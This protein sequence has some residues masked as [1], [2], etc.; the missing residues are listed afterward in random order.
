MTL[1]RA[2]SLALSLVVVWCGSKIMADQ[3]EAEAVAFEAFEAS[4]SS[5]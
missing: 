1:M 4:I 2:E 3:D 5:L